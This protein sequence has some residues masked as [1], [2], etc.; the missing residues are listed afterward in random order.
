[1]KLDRTLAQD[2]AKYTT[3][4]GSQESI[5]RI[6]RELR[7]V[8]SAMSSPDVMYRFAEHV[9]TFG[10]VPVAICTACSI[11]ERT[12]RL[13]SWSVKWAISVIAACR[14]NLNTEDFMIADGLHPL[15]IEEYAG[16]FIRLT[17][18]DD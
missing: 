13:N 1:M 14:M 2:I 7:K 15:R 11:L 9:K 18:V 4:D 3:N 12:K 6:R 17:T 8:R 5:N 16:A 10:R